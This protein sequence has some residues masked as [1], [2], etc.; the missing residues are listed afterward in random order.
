M[1]SIHKCPI[2]KIGL[3]YV[4]STTDIPS[5]SKTVFVKSTVPEPPLACVDKGKAVIGGEGLVD[6]EIIKR[7][8]TKRSPPTCHHYGVSATSDLDGLND[9]VR[10]SYQDTLH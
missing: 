2:D 6:E 3:G 4:A 10:R 1:L 7:P 8:P 9:K 5:T